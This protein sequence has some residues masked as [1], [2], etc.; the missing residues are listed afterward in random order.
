MMTLRSRLPLHIY[1]K[2]FDVKESIKSFASK[3]EVITNSNAIIYSIRLLIVLLALLMGYL[4]TPKDK[5]DVSSTIK[6][7]QRSI[8][9]TPYFEKIK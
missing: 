2:Y 7:E 5:V 3:I 4:H 1:Q 8:S 9:T 6:S